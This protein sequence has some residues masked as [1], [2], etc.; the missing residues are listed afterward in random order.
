MKSVVLHLLRNLIY[1][2]T[3]YFI[4]CINMYF[5]SYIELEYMK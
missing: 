4:L 2:K 1:L 3:F 5:K